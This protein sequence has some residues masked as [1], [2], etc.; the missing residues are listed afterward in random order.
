MN[1]GSD[2]STKAATTLTANEEAPDSSF[3]EVLRHY[4]E[5]HSLT[6]TA[7][8]DLVGLNASY[9]HRLEM[10][11]RKPSRKTTIALADALNL[12]AFTTNQWLMA[13]EHGPLPISSLTAS[14]PNARGVS[15]RRQAK[16]SPARWGAR[17]ENV[18]IE[19]PVLN[20]LSRAL[21]PADPYE[22]KRAATIISKGLLLATRGL[23]AQCR[24]A[25]IPAAGR[26]YR[27]HNL[28]EHVLQRLLIRAIR[29]ASDCGVQE[30]ILVLA[31]QTNEWFYAPLKEAFE[32][33][34]QQ[35]MDLKVCTQAETTGLGDAILLTEDFVRQRPF[36]VILPDDFLNLTEAT[37]SSK[38]QQLQVLVDHFSKLSDCSLVAVTATSRRKM[39]QYGIVEL[40]EDPL[41]KKT[42][43][44]RRL[45]EK[46]QMGHAILRSPD[47]FSIVGRYIL[48]PD[49]FDF[50]K[51]LQKQDR[52][53]LELTT[54]LEL[55]RR[56]GRMIRGVALK[57]VRKDF[58]EVIDKANEFIRDFDVEASAQTKSRD[59][60]YSR[61]G[62]GERKG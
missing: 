36:A 43:P 54:A 26:S 14:V 29:E 58:G 17:L 52:E 11:N 19:A 33:T 59:L 55:M 37:R 30:V 10:G 25:V 8:A 50:L 44:V 56:A 51:A 38:I 21:E 16:I 3:G 4:R 40:G 20:R 62:S 28:P 46:P 35:L 12:D 41:S 22:R 6:R 39:S 34:G 47:A 7:L 1:T 60:N 15:R 57:G 27:Q 49:I 53:R 18:G 48:Q 2:K 42:R 13:A 61:A 32:A 31:P 9:V 5:S 23:E 24:V 45:I